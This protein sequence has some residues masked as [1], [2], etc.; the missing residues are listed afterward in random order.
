MSEPSVETARTDSGSARRYGK[1]AALLEK[2]MLQEDTYDER[3][4]PALE[5]ELS[6]GGVR[7]QVNDEPS[8]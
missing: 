2:W 6:N 8:T 4:W 3:I 1:A 7:C 5:D